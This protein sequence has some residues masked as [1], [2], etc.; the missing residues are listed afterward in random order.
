MIAQKGVCDYSA[1][2]VVE[3]G[4]ILHEPSPFGQSHP[5]RGFPGDALAQ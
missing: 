4:P 5:R 3:T 1:S 2:A